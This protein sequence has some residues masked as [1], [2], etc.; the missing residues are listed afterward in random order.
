MAFDRP[1]LYFYNFKRSIREFE[2][3][4]RRIETPDEKDYGFFKNYFVENPEITIFGFSLGGLRALACFLRKPAKYHSC[5]TFNSGFNLRKINTEG[6]HLDAKSWKKTF[7][8]ITRLVDSMKFLNAQ[9]DMKIV[10]FFRGLYLGRDDIED[11][12]ASLEKHSHKYLSIQSGADTLFENTRQWDANIARPGHGLN[13]LTIAGVGHVPTMD[14]R[15]DNWLS[16]V[17]ESIVYFIQGAKDVHWAHAELETK[18]KELIEA[19]PFFKKIKARTKRNNNYFIKFDFS[20]AVF[21]ELKK[22]IK[23][24]GKNAEKFE[25][26]YYISKAF[27]PKFS[28]LLE[29]VTK[30][31]LKEEELKDNKKNK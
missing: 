10:D 6:L 28:E 14:L 2:E 7:V 26:F 15:W 3:L 4:I 31:Q 18:I 21:E 8:D 1:E 22:Q 13:R 9:T 23:N 25:E 30:Q 24:N 16:R 27:Y 17:A 12:I 11:L 5:I 19:T 20:F 29:K